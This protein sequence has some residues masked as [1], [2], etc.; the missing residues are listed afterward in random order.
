MKRT[1]RRL[2]ATTLCALMLAAPASMFVAQQPAR[3]A[4]SIPLEVRNRLAI[5]RTAEP[6]T[7]GVPLPVSAAV[8]SVADLNILDGAGEQVPSQFSITARWG[9]APGDGGKPA[10]WLLVTFLADVAPSA[11][12]TYTLASGAPNST[13]T[14]LHK[15]SDTS[16]ELVIDTGAAS[17]KISKRK[18]TFFE[19][20][21]VGGT[22]V[23]DSSQNGV[24]MTEQGG[25]AARS[26]D[27]KPAAVT[28]IEEGPVRIAVKVEGNLG[29]TVPAQ[30]D[31]FTYMYFYPGKT[32]TRVIH[33]AGNH[34]LLQLSPEYK[35]LNYNYYDDGSVTFTRYDIQHHLSD[36]ASAPA[37]YIPSSGGTLQGQADNLSVLQ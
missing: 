16:D 10:R 7:T 9:G 20:V 6:V 25:A 8:T 29:S 11:T 35:W 18:G 19:R 14:A 23:T 31:Y 36:P 15:G 27:V 5:A 28:V 13:A 37:W 30:S 34:G 26:F 12:A 1:P 22:T 2:A 4:V 17:F 24:V 3:A 33:T 32:Y 21:V